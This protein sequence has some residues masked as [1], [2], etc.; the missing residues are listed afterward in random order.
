MGQ[1]QADAARERA[2]VAEA[3][4]G[5]AARVAGAEGDEEAE[6]RAK[7]EDRDVALGGAVAPDRVL[8]E[9]RPRISETRVGT[10]KTSQGGHHAV[11]RSIGSCWDGT[12][13]GSRRRVLRWL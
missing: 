11:G 13:N 8:V 9:V 1:A 10:R 5:V 12:Q 2:V 3:A 4:L 7:A 6:A